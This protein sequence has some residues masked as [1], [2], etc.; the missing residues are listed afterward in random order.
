MLMMTT[1]TAI[2]E[3]LIKNVT[4]VLPRILSESTII[5][6]VAFYVNNKCRELSLIVQLGIQSGIHG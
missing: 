2:L 5:G 4:G 6:M 1:N 3:D